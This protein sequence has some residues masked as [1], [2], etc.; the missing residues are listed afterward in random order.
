[1]RPLYKLK[2]VGRLHLAFTKYNYTSRT[3]WDW[4]VDWNTLA[5]PEVNLFRE[6]CKGG[7]ICQ[8]K[9]PNASSSLQKLAEEHPIP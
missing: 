6:E 7:R 1:M 3:V 4:Q 2:T 9:E 8:K 5:K